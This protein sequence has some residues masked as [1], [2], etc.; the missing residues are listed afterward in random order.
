MNNRTPL[1][2]RYAQVIFL[3]LLIGIMFRVN[4]DYGQLE[5]VID[6]EVTRLSKDIG[7]QLDDDIGHMSAKYRAI[8]KN[9]QHNKRFVELV[10]SRDTKEL[11]K[12]LEY[13]YKSMKSIDPHLHIMHILDTNS[14][15]ILR[16]HKPES[17]D[18]N[19]TNVRDIVRDANINRVNNIGFE[20]GLNGIAYRITSPLIT[21]DKE[22]I[23]VLEFGVKTSY[24]TD[25]ID[26]IVNLEAQVLVETEDLKILLKKEKRETLG[27]YSI[28]NTSPVF[29]IINSKIDLNQKYQIIDAEEKKYVVFNDF[30]LNSYRG[31]KDARIIFVKDITEVVQTYENSLFMIYAINFSIVFIVVL[32]F[33]RVRKNMKFLQNSLKE[34]NM[35]LEYKV[36]QRTDEQNTLLSL[37]NNGD[38]VLFKWKNNKSWS[39]EFASLGVVE[40]L[41]YTL[42]D[43]K[44][45]KI[46]YS[47]CIHKEDLDRFIMGDNDSN[48]VRS[49]KQIESEA[50]ANLISKK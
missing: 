1:T 19:L 34:L 43:I 41:G 10:K 32:L 47:S 12:E 29:K 24:F 21:K 4:Y 27:K 44:T 33:F 22:H 49:Q 17:F 13:D 25:E 40:L 14:V 8:A 2:G 37:F 18:D 5:N 50:I 36:K 48:L 3:L 26:N 11:Y 45:S 38:S 16:M 30:T 7:S 28:I 20:V 31:S 23:G 9:Y 15:T 39:V 35:T 6:N 42:E 46:T